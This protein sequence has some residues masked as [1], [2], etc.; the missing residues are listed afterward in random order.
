VTGLRSG[1][2]ARS[3]SAEL[4]RCVRA[5]LRIDSISSPKKS[6]RRTSISGVDVDDPPRWLPGLASQHSTGCSRP[7][8]VLDQHVGQY[9]SPTLSLSASAE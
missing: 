2:A 5:N 9:S 6:M 1:E 3:S 4:L 8:Q 7:K